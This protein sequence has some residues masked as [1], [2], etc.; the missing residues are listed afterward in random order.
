MVEEMKPYHFIIP[1]GFSLY[2]NSSII[3]QTHVKIG[4]KMDNVFKTLDERGFIKQTTNAEQVAH[5]LVEE[6]VTYYV[7]FDPTA[8]SLHVG[9]SRSHN[10]DGT[11]AT[12]RT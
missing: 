7:G 9:S 10:G 8:P 12:R 11:P 2:K 4:K 5:L 3:Y 1:K 6:Q